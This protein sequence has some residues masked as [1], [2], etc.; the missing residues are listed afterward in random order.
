MSNT[1]ASCSLVDPFSHFDYICVLKDALVGWQASANALL[2][3]AE[4]I[5]MCEYLI[6]ERNWSLANGVISEHFKT[7]IGQA[8]NPRNI[9]RVFINGTLYSL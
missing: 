1:V 8:F 3:L 6:K 4:F 5:N 7:Y 2:A 9:R